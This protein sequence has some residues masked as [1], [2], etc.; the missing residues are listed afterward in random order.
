MEEGET[1]FDQVPEPLPVTVLASLSVKVHDP[2]AV[3][4]PLIEVLFPAVIEVPE[5]V[6]AATGRL[7]TVMAFDVVE[8]PFIAVAQKLFAEVD[9]TV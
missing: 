6:I 8:P 4:V 1:D 9:C 2:E 7:L 5:L 3:I